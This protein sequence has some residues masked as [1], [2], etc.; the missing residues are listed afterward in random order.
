MVCDIVGKTRKSG[1]GQSCF[2][3]GLHYSSM[4]VVEKPEVMF[5]ETTE[6][7]RCSHGTQFITLKKTAIPL[8]AGAFSWA[9]TGYIVISVRKWML[10]IP[11]L[12]FSLP[13]PYQ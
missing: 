8:V 9:H 1:S 2:L 10:C 4:I 7:E 5:K 6:T 3:L 13:C 12:S 11:L